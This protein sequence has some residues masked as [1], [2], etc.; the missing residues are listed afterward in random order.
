MGLDLKRA[1]HGMRTSTKNTGCWVTEQVGNPTSTTSH[2]KIRET[3]DVA[4]E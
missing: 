4:R 1:E 3:K 2:L